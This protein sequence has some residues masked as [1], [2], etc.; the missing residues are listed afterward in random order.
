[1]RDPAGGPR[2]WPP[3][4]A[5]AYHARMMP[6]GGHT[7]VTVAA[8]RFP[9]DE[10]EVRALFEEYI[11]SLGIDLSFQDVGRELAQIPGKY[12]E[13]RGV[14]LLARAGVRLAWAGGAAIC[15]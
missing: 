5:N 8:A 2:Q 14:I 6:A 7:L 15:R 12:A 11:R 10:D 9:A 1:M 3:A 4:A 13:P